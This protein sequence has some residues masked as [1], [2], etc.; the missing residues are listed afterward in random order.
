[1]R[2]NDEDKWIFSAEIVH[3]PVISSETFSQAEP[4]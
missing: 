4:C 2:W 3:P 1:M